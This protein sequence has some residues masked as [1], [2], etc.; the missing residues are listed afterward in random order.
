MF[1]CEGL[2]TFEWDE[3]VLE[4][5][6]TNGLVAVAENGGTEKLSILETNRLN[7]RL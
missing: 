6:G 3:V 4:T 7:L 5:L 2:V 1:C